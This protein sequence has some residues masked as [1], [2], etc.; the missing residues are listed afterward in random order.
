MVGNVPI[1]LK[2]SPNERD[3]AALHRKG[4]RGFGGDRLG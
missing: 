2:K 3:E 4:W 1:S